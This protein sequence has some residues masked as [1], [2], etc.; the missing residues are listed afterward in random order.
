MEPISV[1]YYNE[2]CTIYSTLIDN[3]NRLYVPINQIPDSNSIIIT[4]PQGYRYKRVI[5]PQ[6]Y[7]LYERI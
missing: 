1:S 7:Y 6:D 5:I 3:Q 2:K 4:D